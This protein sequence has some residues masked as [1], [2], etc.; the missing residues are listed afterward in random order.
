MDAKIKNK[1][2]D[3][4]K[5]GNKE[6]DNV[7]GKKLAMISLGIGI[8]S[9]FLFYINV[10]IST[11]SNNSDM[12]WVG[13]LMIYFICLMVEF[14]FRKKVKETGYKGKILSF[15]N[16]CAVIQFPLAVLGALAFLGYCGDFNKFDPISSWMSWK[17]V[18]TYAGNHGYENPTQVLSN[19]NLLLIIIFAMAFIQLRITI[20]RKNITDSKQILL[21]FTTIILFIV[22]IMSAFLMYRR[23]GRQTFVFSEI[24]KDIK[25]YPI[26]DQFG[27]D[28]SAI[29]DF[30]FTSK[31]YVFLSVILFSSYIFILL[32]I[33]LKKIPWK[34]ITGVLAGLILSYGIVT[35]VYSQ[36]LETYWNDYV[37]IY[38]SRSR[39]N[40]FFAD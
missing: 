12:R 25:Y 36:K 10:R 15:G 34:I 28:S 37:T 11:T 9:I 3:F 19:I 6:H 24:F 1:L 20:K 39:M 2:T 33:Y 13:L 35:F 30:C 40:D 29:Y 23:V 8:F 27:Q 14:F 22:G 31:I 4:I 26:T 17:E 7:E 21:W 16:L 38:Y 32:A 5:A 18:A